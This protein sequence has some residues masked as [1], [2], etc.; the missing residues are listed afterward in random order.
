MLAVRGVVVVISGAVG[1]VEEEDDTGRE[2]VSPLIVVVGCT[3]VVV[4]R[5]VEFS[6]VAVVVAVADVEIDAE[7]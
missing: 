6:V 1:E 5:V 2:V 4:C 7:V 3:R